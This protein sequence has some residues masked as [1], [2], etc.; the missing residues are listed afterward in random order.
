M[1][2]LQVHGIPIP[3]SIVVSSRIHLSFA[4]GPDRLRLPYIVAEAGV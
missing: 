4:I 3:P 2:R 1:T